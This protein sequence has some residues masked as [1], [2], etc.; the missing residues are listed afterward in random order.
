[1]VRMEPILCFAGEERVHD[2]RTQNPS[3]SDSRKRFT[4]SLTCK[5][6]SSIQI[7]R[8]RLK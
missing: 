7:F 2:E 6:S 1:M 5:L 3:L 4:G 8:E